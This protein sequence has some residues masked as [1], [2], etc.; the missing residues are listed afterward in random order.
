MLNKIILIEVP[1]FGLAVYS[2]EGYE[3]SNKDNATYETLFHDNGGYCYFSLDE[4]KINSNELFNKNNDVNYLKNYTVVFVSKNDKEKYCI[5]GWYE[6]AEIFKFRQS[7][8]GVNFHIKAESCDVVWLP[9]DLESVYTDSIDRMRLAN[10]SE[11]EK[12]KNLITKFDKEKRINIIF[13]DFLH[14]MPSIDNKEFNDKIIRIEELELDEHFKLLKKAKLLYESKKELQ[15]LEVLL[16]IFGYLAQ[17]SYLLKTAELLYKMKPD[18]ETT[19]TFAFQLIFSDRIDEGIKL[20]NS[21]KNQFRYD[22][23]IMYHLGIGYML[24]GY[25]TDAYNNFDSIKSEAY[26]DQ[27]E[28]FKQNIEYIYPNLNKQKTE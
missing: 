15:P 1:T 3:V 13:E 27:V 18:F 26:K 14:K 6:R 5:E 22:D 28:K 4:Y 8:F 16:R 7:Y 12:I 9:Y 2:K 10:D 11:I 21:L 23:E 25:P 24:T 19:K 20:L 17:D